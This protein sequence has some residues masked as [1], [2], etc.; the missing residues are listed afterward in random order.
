VKAFLVLAAIL[1]VVWLLRSRQGSGA[2]GSSSR[3]GGNKPQDMVRCHQCGMHIPAN[4]SIA[5]KQGSYCCTEHLR[6]SES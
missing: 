6:L 2:S 4:E 1:L 3:T 5:G